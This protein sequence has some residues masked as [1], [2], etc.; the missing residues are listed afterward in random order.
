[1]PLQGFYIVNPWQFL[2]DYA[3]PLLAI[4]LG[5]LAAYFIKNKYIS[6]I[7]LS[8]VA[9]IINFIFAVASGALFFSQYA[10]VGQSAII[11]SLIYNSTYIIPNYGLSAGIVLVSYPYI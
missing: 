1:M 11:Y 10:P 3:Y 9:W 5:G 7:V 2:L 4:P 8:I 6:I